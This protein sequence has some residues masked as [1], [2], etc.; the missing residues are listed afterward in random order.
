M[1]VVTGGAGFIGSNLLAALEERGERDLVV[2]DRLGGDGKWRNVAKR[3]L[4]DIVA[5]EPLFQ[6]LDTH[7]GPVNVV[8]H[9]GP[10]R[11]TRYPDPHPLVLSSPAPTPAPC[12][13]CS[14][15]G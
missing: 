4:A 5:P 2:C 15:P 8:F 11:D 1:I 14:S 10:I 9:L 3:E 12:R 13:W 7:A 6:F